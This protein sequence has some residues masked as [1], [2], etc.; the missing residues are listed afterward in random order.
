MIASKGRREWAYAPKD[1]IFH[2]QRS[3]TPEKD[4]RSISSTSNENLH[5]ANKEFR[6]AMNLLENLSRQN[7][8]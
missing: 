1:T 7:L 5:R 3:P 6:T 8:I 4:S 2:L